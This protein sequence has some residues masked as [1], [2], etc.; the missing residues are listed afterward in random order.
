MCVD[1]NF[2][3]YV[4]GGGRKNK[5]LLELIEKKITGNLRIID[6]LGI[7]GG[8]IESQLLVK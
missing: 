2:D 1:L 7:D 8:Y 4:S 3:V 6:S 5:F